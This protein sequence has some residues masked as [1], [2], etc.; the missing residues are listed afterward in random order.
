M[1]NFEGYKLTH[2]GSSNPSAERITL[3]SQ[4]DGP[5]NPFLQAFPEV[6][7]G[8]PADEETLRKFLSIERD[9]GANELSHQTAKQIQD[10]N[11]KIMVVVFEVLYPRGILDSNRR[12][13][14]NWPTPEP[15]NPLREETCI[16][17]RNIFDP[18][19]TERSFIR[20]IRIINADTIAKL[21]EM[22]KETRQSEGFFADLH[23][24]G[25]R[26]PNA[27]AS[28]SHRISETPD[29]IPDYNDA[30]TN[31]SKLLGERA[32]DII[33]RDTDDRIVTHATLARI[34]RKNLQRE[35]IPVHFNKPYRTAPGILSTKLLE[36]CPGLLTDI[37]KHYV[38]KGTAD[39]VAENLWNLE[40]DPQKI[41]QL[42]KI[43][44]ATLLQVLDSK[45]HSRFKPRRNMLINN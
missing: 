15:I 23:T 10:T 30:W 20:T 16:A 42:A 29:N 3:V 31:P 7:K 9:T 41:E 25:P 12:D 37:P 18:K 36:T 6:I 14:A 33:T 35:G 19:K 38:A 8:C 26:E 13:F 28:P 5:S 45:T 43:Y 11:S 21:L 32:V 40:L 39:E 34:L 24:M 4:H 17:V 44:A 27:Q 22:V 2:Y 1:A